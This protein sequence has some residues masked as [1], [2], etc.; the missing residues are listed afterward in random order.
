[1]LLHYIS[2]NK[3]H[4]LGFLDGQLLFPPLPQNTIISPTFLKNSFAW[5]TIL[6]WLL[7]SFS[8]LKIS[9]QWGLA[10]IAIRIFV[11]SGF[12]LFSWKVLLLTEWVESSVP[13]NCL[14]PGGQGYAQLVSLTL[15]A[16]VC[17]HS[18]LDELESPWE[19]LSSF[20]AHRSFT[21]KP[22]VSQSCPAGTRCAWRGAAVETVPWLAHS[23]DHP[24]V[25]AQAHSSHWVAQGPMLQ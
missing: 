14:L 10:A 1:M 18:F 13:G 8:P 20:V 9:Y 2:A 11:S 3:P 23:P 5:F 4:S 17:L 6:S 22:H 15:G 25:L 7:F 12:C 24:V 21:A 19:T 16:D